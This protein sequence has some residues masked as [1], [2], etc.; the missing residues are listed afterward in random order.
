MQTLHEIRELLA[1]AGRA[2]SRPLGQHF[3]IDGNLMGKLLELADVPPGTTVLEI[4]PGTGSLT[5]E[6]A[7]GGAR[8]V[9]VELDRSL[10]AILRMRVGQTGRVTVVHADALAGKR[11]FSR[12]LLETLASAGGPVH[13]V[14]NLP[15]NVAVPIILNALHCS[16]AAV[17]GRGGV[18]FDRLTFTV[19]KELAERLRAAPGGKEYGPAAVVVSLLAKATPGRTIPATAFWPPPKVQSQMVRLDFDAAPAAELADLDLLSAVLSAVFGQRRK[20][21]S[22]AIRRRDLTLDRQALAAAMASAGI[23]TD[24]RA[25]QVAPEAYRRLANLMSSNTGGRDLVQ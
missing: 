12:E 21:L 9:A 10:A 22:S 19:Q 8:V 14:S 7:A 15:Y 16:W 3:L 25:E 6:L 2:P 23:D 24:L 1:S 18:R 11:S 17:R 20:K 5:E 13:L 4:G